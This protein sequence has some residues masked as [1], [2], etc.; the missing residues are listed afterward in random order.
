VPSLDHYLLQLSAVE[1]SRN[2]LQM[3]ELGRKDLDAGAFGVIIGCGQRVTRAR[4]R[5]RVFDNL[6]DYKMAKKAEATAT[7]TAPKKVRRY[8]SIEGGM[9]F[10]LPSGAWKEVLFAEMHDKS[11][12]DC[13]FYGAG[14]KFQ[15]GVYARGKDEAPATDEEALDFIGGYT[16]G[17]LFDRTRGAGGV[18]MTSVAAT[19]YKVAFHGKNGKNPTA[20]ETKA[21]VAKALA[22]E[23]GANY[24]KVKEQYDA[25]KGASGVEL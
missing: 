6:G 19:L 1:Q 11:K 9:K 13:L 12:T 14:Q 16:D 18:T 20:E 15:D 2:T 24:A 3:T 8:A 17:S 21:W 4:T 23:S 7:V 10:M 25:L 5:V 22:D